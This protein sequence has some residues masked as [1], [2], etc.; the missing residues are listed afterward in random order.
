MTYADITES[1]SMYYKEIFF[2]YWYK[3][4]HDNITF[5]HTSSNYYTTLQVRYHGERK[6]NDYPMANKKTR[7]IKLTYNYTT[8]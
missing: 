2:L 6:D 8:I 5:Y 4:L 7:N 1:F 3:L